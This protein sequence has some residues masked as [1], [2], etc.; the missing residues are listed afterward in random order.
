MHSITKTGGEPDAHKK[1]RNV[2]PDAHVYADVYFLYYA[3]SLLQR[4]LMICF[5]A[6]RAWDEIPAC[7]LFPAD[8][9]PPSF[10]AQEG[11][12]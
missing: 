3:F 8:M 12:D 2:S 7:F 5:I 9:I 1:D 10:S 11:P 4:Y 6:Q